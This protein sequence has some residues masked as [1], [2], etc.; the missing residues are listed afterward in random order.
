[1]KSEGIHLK[2]IAVD[3]ILLIFSFLM[4]LL[5][6]QKH[7]DVGTNYWKLLVVI[8]ICWI[9]SGLVSNKYKLNKNE[10]RY[11]K[12]I[13]PLLTSALIFIGLLTLFIYSVNW[14]NL[15]RFVVF[16]FFLL[17]VFLE[18]LFLSEN[19]MPFFT[20]NIEGRI[21]KFSYSLFGF[22]LIVSFL[23]FFLVYFLKFGDL[24]LD[25]EGYQQTL[26]LLIFVWFLLVLQS[27]ALVC[28]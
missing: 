16:G 7:L 25:N 5:I 13:E 28:I 18:I 2:K 14:I 4:I 15:S 21:Q 6:K 12:K 3:F 17:F 1:M 22:D 9:I 8:I 24:F 23:G 20:K 10:R 11:L 27:L 26:I 19:Y